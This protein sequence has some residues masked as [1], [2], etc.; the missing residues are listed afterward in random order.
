MLL[1][2][3]KNKTSKTDRRVVLQPSLVIRESSLRR[4]SKNGRT[5]HT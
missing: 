5:A 2:L 1:R 4:A 3:L